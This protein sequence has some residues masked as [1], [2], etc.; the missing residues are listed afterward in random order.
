MAGVGMVS[1]VPRIIPRSNNAQSPSRE[2][3]SVAVLAAICFAAILVKASSP[4]PSWAT[5]SR[6]SETRAQAMSTLAVNQPLQNDSPA[7]TPAPDAASTEVPLSERLM[8]HSS[9]V[10]TPLPISTT[11]EDRSQGTALDEHETVPNVSDSPTETTSTTDGSV[12]LHIAELPQASVTYPVAPG[13]NLSGNVNL[14]ALIGLDGTIKE[15]TVL[16]GNR[17]L[18]NATLQAVRNW[19]YVPYT[20]Q[21]HT[22]EAETEIRFHFVGQEAVSITFA[23]GAKD[24]AFEDKTGYFR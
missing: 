10:A 7:E 2:W 15:I 19:H 9:I 11:L 12:R 3:V 23:S 1:N 13:S 18:V 4:W 21:G 20:V 17:A 5:N 16:N 22:V 6:I 24:P 8:V 14:K